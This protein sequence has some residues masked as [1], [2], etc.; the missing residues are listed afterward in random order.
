MRDK[1]IKYAMERHCRMGG[2]YFY[3]LE[4]PNGLNTCCA[5]SVLK[6]REIPFQKEGFL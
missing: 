1:V 5:L 3:R 2:F 6:L 4:E